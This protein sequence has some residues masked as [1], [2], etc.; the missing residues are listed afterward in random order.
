MVRTKLKNLVSGTT[1]E[2]TFRMTETFQTAQVDT[3]DAVYSYDDGDSLVFMDA[4]ISMKSRS[5]ASP[6]RTLIW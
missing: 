1:V 3:N 2:D 5:R 6:S 4:V